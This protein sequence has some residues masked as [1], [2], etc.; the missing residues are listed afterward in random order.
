MTIT[1]ALHEAMETLDDHA[2]QIGS[3]PYASIAAELQKV[4]NSMQQQAAETRRVFA[5]D[6]LLDVP[7]CALSESMVKFTADR[8][9]MKALVRKKG[10]Q[11]REYNTSCAAVLGT[12]WKIEITDALLPYQ[13]PGSLEDVR[14]GIL[15]LLVARSGFLPQIVARLTR[16]AITPGMLCPTD[17]DVEPVDGDDGLGPSAEDFLFYEPRMLRWLLSKGELEPWPQLGIGNQPEYMSRLIAMVNGEG[18]DD[19]KVNE[20]CTCRIC[21]GVRIP[22]MDCPVISP[23][24]SECESDGVEEMVS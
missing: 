16:L 19:R 20:P 10:V 18:G 4:A 13:D 17:M 24:P 9:F 14:N 15:T 21:K 8:K 3:G 7:A 23:T 1:A 12:A 5:I 11:L 6:L 22:T 2:S